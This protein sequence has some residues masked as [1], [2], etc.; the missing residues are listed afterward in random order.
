MPRARPPEMSGGPHGAPRRAECSAP[1]RERGVESSPPGEA[2]RGSRRPGAAWCGT[3]RSEARARRRG[4]SARS[5]SPPER[6]RAERRAERGGPR[7]GS[8]ARSAAARRG[9]ASSVAPERGAARSA[10]T[11]E[12]LGAGRGAPRQGRGAPSAARSVAPPSKPRPGARLPGEDAAERSVARWGSAVRRAARAAEHCAPNEARRGARHPGKPMRRSGGAE[13]SESA[14][15]SASPSAAPRESVQ[16]GA[17]A[18]SRMRP[19]RGS[20]C[21]PCTA[22]AVSRRSGRQGGSQRLASGAPGGRHEDL[23][24]VDRRELVVRV[25]AVRLESCSSPGL[26]RKCAGGGRGVAPPHGADR[27]RE[28]RAASSP[29]QSPLRARSCRRCAV[30]PTAGV[31]ACSA[32]LVIDFQ[33]RPPPTRERGIMKKE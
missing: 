11:R 8:T 31:S 9:M 14:A 18:E 15:R 3:Q 33:L 22:R 17:R 1:R 32:I 6:R 16:R 28:L 10:A 4:G 2:R 12:E 29:P 13:R 24:S 21:G 26:C 5:V 27:R 30:G 7:R 23:C 19:P 25:A 20:L